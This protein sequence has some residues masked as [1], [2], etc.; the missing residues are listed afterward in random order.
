MNGEKAKGRIE[1]KMLKSNNITNEQIIDFLVFL[2][3]VADMK[4]MIL[5]LHTNFMG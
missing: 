1:D 3:I 2:F 5:N 4:A